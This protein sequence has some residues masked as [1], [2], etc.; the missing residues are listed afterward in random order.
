MAAL[1]GFGYAVAVAGLVTDG[2]AARTTHDLIASR[3][4]FAAGI[5]S[6]AGVVA[7]DILGALWLVLRGRSVRTSNRPTLDA[8]AAERVAIDQPCTSLAASAGQVMDR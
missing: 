8:T 4:L 3:G 2:D 5:L 6:L 7:L 1:A